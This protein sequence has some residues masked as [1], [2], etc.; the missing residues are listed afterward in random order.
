MNHTILEKVRRMLITANLSKEVLGLA[1][2]SACY[3]INGTPCVPLGFETTVNIWSGKMIPYSHLKAFGCKAF[4]LVPKEPRPKLEDKDVP[5]VVE[6]INKKLFRSKDVV[7]HED[8][9]VADIGKEVIDH[10]DH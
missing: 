8:Q 10:A 5:L 2:S 1:V 4:T 7:F 3:L 6:S 9:T